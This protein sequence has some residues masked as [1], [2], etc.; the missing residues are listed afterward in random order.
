MWEKDN[1]RKGDLKK[2]KT[3]QAHSEKGSSE[4]DFG[5]RTTLIYANLKL[6]NLQNAYHKIVNLKNM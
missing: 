6:P 4:K 5:E 3:N 2:D 1:S